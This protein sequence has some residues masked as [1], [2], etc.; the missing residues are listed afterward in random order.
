[1]RAQLWLMVAASGALSACSTLSS[2]FSSEKSVTVDEV[3]RLN[4]CNTTAAVP[5]LSLLP[6]AAA[7]E[8]WQSA[9][10]VDLIGVDPLP[11]AVSYVVVELGAQQRSGYSIAVSRHADV[12]NGVLRLNAT[13]FEPDNPQ[14]A[15]RVPGSPC[16]L[17]GLPTARYRSLELADPGGTVLA[18]I[19]SVPPVQLPTSAK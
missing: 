8:L 5:Q 16:V 18:S 1:M 2:V 6:D 12:R 10:H 3:R 9:R 17:V 19:L 15:S 11:Y 13:L 4:V 7:V 14:T